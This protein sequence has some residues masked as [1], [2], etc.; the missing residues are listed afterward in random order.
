MGNKNHSTVILANRRIEKQL[1]EDVEV[2]RQTPAGLEKE[3]LRGIVRKIEVQLGK[4][5]AQAAPAQVMPISQHP[6]VLP[7]LQPSQPRLAVG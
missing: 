4:V 3:Q 7:E 6:A 5:P 1:K 2:Q